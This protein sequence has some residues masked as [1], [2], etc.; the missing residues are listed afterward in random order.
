MTLDE[1]VSGMSPPATSAEIIALDEAL[2]EVDGGYYP[3]AELA[4]DELSPAELAEIGQLS[5]DAYS[6]EAARLA[7]D[8]QDRAALAKRPSAEVRLARA[9]QRVEYGSYL[10]PPLLSAPLGVPRDA[11][12]LFVF[13]CGEPDVLGRCGARYHSPQCSTV[14]EAAAA[15]GSAAEAEAWNATLKGRTSSA[16]VAAAQLANEP[17]PGS[18]VDAWADLLTPPGGPGSADPELISRLLQDMGE[19]GHLPPRREQRPLPQ[20]ADLA[21]RMGLR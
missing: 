17:E 12:G 21:E 10:P 19:A 11:R 15:T 5:D 16:D 1:I 18:G 9:L 4:G 6:A 3:G 20:V 2:A 8:E 14:T 13:T 7:E